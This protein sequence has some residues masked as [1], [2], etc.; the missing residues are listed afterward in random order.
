MGDENT[1]NTSPTRQN[2]L[3]QQGIRSPF[4]VSRFPQG[5]AGA[6]MVPPTRPQP[7]YSLPLPR[8]A[9]SHAEKH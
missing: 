5:Q 9:T 3:R 6:G 4:P 8:V 7:M 1:T 2:G